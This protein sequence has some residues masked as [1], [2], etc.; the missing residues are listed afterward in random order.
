M[1]EVKVLIQA[2]IDAEG[3]PSDRVL[4][5]PLGLTFSVTREQMQRL[6]GEGYYLGIKHLPP[7]LY[8]ELT[9]VANGR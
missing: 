7:H 4:V 5:T 3:N 1:S 6:F 8:T 9:K 2:T